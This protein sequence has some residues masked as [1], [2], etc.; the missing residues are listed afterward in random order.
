MGKGKARVE[1]SSYCSVR[2][3]WFSMHVSALFAHHDC[4]SDTADSRLPMRLLRN[5]M[6][7]ASSRIFSQVAKKRPAVA[8]ILRIGALCKAD[9]VTTEAFKEALT[10]H[11]CNPRQR[12]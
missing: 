4:F 6:I 2:A 8:T 1:A 11:A 12:L 3:A 7:A 9:E 10:P 5:G